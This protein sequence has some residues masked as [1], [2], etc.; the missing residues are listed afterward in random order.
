MPTSKDKPKKTFKRMRD[1][2]KKR[3]RDL[4]IASLLASN[5]WSGLEEYDNDKSELS[6]DLQEFGMKFRKLYFSAKTMKFKDW[7][8]EM[9][10]LLD[11]IY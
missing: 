2:M 7:L 1:A 9:K 8:K 3:K 6:E 5:D 11:A 4:K 10:D